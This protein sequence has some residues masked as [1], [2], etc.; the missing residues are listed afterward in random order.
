MAEVDLHRV[1][2]G[3]LRAVDQRYTASRRTLVE[4]LAKAT[5]PLMISEI[6]RQGSGL[7]QSSAYRNLQVL[8]QAGAVRRVAGDDG[9]SRYELAEDLIGHHHHLVCSNCGGVED[10]EAP[11]QFERA[12]ARAM[13]QVATAS[14]F[15]LDS[16]HL[17][18]RGL[19]RSCA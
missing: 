3:R 8:E 1:V 18:L 11:P 19:C 16:H 14:G 17:Q 9:Y 6:L 7:P 10:F 12:V 13:D 4:L 5:K 2:A 15:A